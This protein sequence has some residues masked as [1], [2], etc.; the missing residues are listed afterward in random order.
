[1]QAVVVN[2]R[3]FFFN[4]SEQKNPK[5]TPLGSSLFSFFILFTWIWDEA[6]GGAA[7][8]GQPTQTDDDVFYLFLQKQK[9]G[10]ELHIYLE[11]GTYHKRLL[12]GLALT[13]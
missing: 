5:K 10:A 4:T 9:T 12:E 2:S 1:M 13:I 8:G 11:E 3:A 6:A 7:G